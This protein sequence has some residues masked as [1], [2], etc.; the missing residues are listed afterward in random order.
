[1]VSNFE[2]KMHQIQFRLG[3][4]SKSSSLRSLQRFLRLLTEF[5]AAYTIKDRKGRGKRK[6]RRGEGTKE[7]E[8]DSIW[9]RSVS[10]PF[11][12]LDLAQKWGGA[13]VR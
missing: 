7:K 8:E 3:L 13:V 12:C 10:A 4:C 6:E 11:S 5:K 9:P 1:V 2:A